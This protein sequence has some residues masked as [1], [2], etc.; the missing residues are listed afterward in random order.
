MNN[1]KIYTIKVGC[2]DSTYRCQIFAFLADIGGHYS[3][4][5]GDTITLHVPEAELVATLEFLA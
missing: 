5:N 4:A 2:T 3:D 1:T